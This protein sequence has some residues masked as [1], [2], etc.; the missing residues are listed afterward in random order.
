MFNSHTRDG[1]AYV[2]AFI[3][4]LGEK[5]CLCGPWKDNGGIFTLLKSCNELLKEEILLFSVTR[6]YEDMITEK[7]WYSLQ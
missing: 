6:D 4:Y 5:L 7:C 2:F 1:E 3:I